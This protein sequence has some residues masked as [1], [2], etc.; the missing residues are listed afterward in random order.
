MVS[1]SF[2]QCERQLV[3]DFVAEVG[4]EGRWAATAGF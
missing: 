1:R 3:A 4:L 2:L